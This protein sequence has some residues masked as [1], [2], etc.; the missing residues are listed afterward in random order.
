MTNF[1]AISAS[2]YPYNVDDILIE[3]AC[4]DAKLGVR[5]EYSDAV[6][7]GVAKASIAILKNFIVLSSES[8]GG[9]S[10]SY[11]VENLKLRIF[12][13]ATDNDLTDIAEQFDT[14]SSITDISDV[15]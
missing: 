13:I 11:D 1:E 4:I 2:L 7:K 10:L 6:K 12:N 3:K 9:C 14:R 8:I 15:W 5:S